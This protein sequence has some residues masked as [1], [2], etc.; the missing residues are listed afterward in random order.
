MNVARTFLSLRTYAFFLKMQSFR[1]LFSWQNADWLIFAILL[2]LAW[3]MPLLG[4]SWLSSIE[5]ACERLAVKRRLAIVAALLIPIAIRVSLLPVF[6]I[7]PPGV[8]DEYSYLL[9]ADTFA[10]G[11]MANPPHPMWI[12]FDTFHVLQHPTYAS[13]Y[14]PAQS[15]VLALGQLLGHP[16]IGVLLSM[17]AMFAVLLWMLQGLL[18]PKWALLGVVLPFLQFGIFSYWMNS[19]WGGTV[20]AIGGALVMGA[21]PRIMRKQNIRDT[22]LLGLGIAVLANSR[23]FEGFVLCVPVAFALLYWLFSRHSPAWRITVPRVV[24]PL[25]CVLMMCFAFIFYYNRQVT[26]GALQFPHALDDQLHQSAPNFV[27]QKLSPPLQFPNHQFDVFYNHWSRNFYNHTWADFLRISW[28]KVTQFYTFFLGAPLLVPFVTFPRMALDRRTRFLLLQ[29]IFCLVGVMAVV[30]FNPHY[31]APLLA[32]F[33]CLLAQ[34]FRHLRRWK[35]RGRPV[36]IGLTR[37]VVLLTA[38]TIPVFLFQTAKDHRRSFD[39]IWGGANWQRADIA[40]QLQSIEGQHLI[41]V[42]YSQTHHDVHHEWVYNAA[43]IDH[44]KIVWAREIPG[45]DVKPL[46]DYF[47]GRTVWLSEPD[48]YPSRLAPYPEKPRH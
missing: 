16:W 33:F 25:S 21:L 13:M 10:H 2:G 20:P 5:R 28:D 18:P 27:W 46:I 30:W 37:A 40:A 26:G 12:F 36:G 3:W 47:K 39:M 15:A 44:A 43:D 8:Q 48:S 34:M 32:T 7:R 38:L 42:R 4:D 6:P 1:Q 31:A 41:I 45:V 22:L 24:I 9:A 14:P 35:F 23:P 29:F 17:G 19:Y 11:R